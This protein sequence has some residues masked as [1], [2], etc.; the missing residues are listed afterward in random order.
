MMKKNIIVLVCFALASISAL[1]QEL[2]LEYNFGYGVYR[3]SG[4]KKTLANTLLN[5]VR[6]KKTTDN[7][8]GNMTNNIRI[9]VQ[10]NRGQA[11]LTYTHHNTSGQN[12]VADYSGEYKLKIRNSGEQLGAFYRLYVL[13]GKFSPFVEFCAGIVFCNSIIEEHLRVGT[14]KQGD[15]TILKGVNIFAQP[16]I[17]VRYKF[18]PFLAVIASAGYEWDPSGS[19]HLKGDR[20]VKSPLMTDWTGFRASAGLITY[21]KMK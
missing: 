14:E 9:G 20:S 21:F 15:K 4:M 17:G 16:T 18:T 1:A 6:G 19:L 12:H 11:G 8:P 13:D 10:M 5:D 7:F 2:T 3:M